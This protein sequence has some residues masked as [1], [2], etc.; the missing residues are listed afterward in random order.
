MRDSD[1]PGS[2]SETHVKH[3]KVLYLGLGSLLL[4]TAC[5]GGDE[6]VDGAIDAPPA[7]GAEADDARVPFVD[8][9]A[10]TGLDF[11]HFNGMSGRFYITEVTAGGVGMLDYDGDGD[12]DLYLP[13][14]A[15]LGPGVTMADVSFPATDGKPLID[16]LYRNDLATGAD[17]RPILRFTD[18]TEESGLAASGYGMGVASGDYDDDGDVD[19]YV[20]N[21]GPNQL[22]QNQ[23]DGTFR[24]V[25]AEAGADDP[26][27][28]V[29]ASFFDYDRDGR[30]DLWI[31]NYLDFTYENHKTCLSVTGAQDYC[32]PAAY[33]PQPDRLLHNEGGGRF[34]DVTREAGV[35]TAYGPALGTVAADLDDD[36]WLDMY[37]TNDG[38][39]NQ[40]WLN[41]HD[42]T[43]TDE[44]LMGGTAV[45]AEGVPEASMG[46]LAVDFTGDGR[47]DL[48]M[49][50]ITGETNTFYENLGGGLFRD[51][52]I[53]TGLAAPS[54]KAT[55][56][57]TAA[58]D[59]DNDGWVDIVAVNGAVRTIEEQA[60]RQV[61]YPLAQPDQLFR[62]VGD[63]R[64]EDLSERAGEAFAVERV[65]RGLAAGDVDNDGDVDLLILDSNAPARLL[66]NQVGQDR[67]WIGLRLLE[68]TGTRDALGAEAGLFRA[69]APPLWRRV[70]T[71]GSFAS[72]HD[73]RVLF[74]LGTETAVERL[75]VRWPSGRVE[76]FPPPPV[77]RY[78]TLTEGT[79]EAVA[80]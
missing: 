32:G 16:R 18:V 14:G 47:D 29:P 23:G 54:K 48:F 40:M 78:T 13:Q 21:L 75:E 17:G 59:Y 31:G 64:F 4:A 22:W 65:S 66:I 30:L 10:E 3:W 72:A 74:G 79:G 71:D 73:P 37:V 61:P 63:G 2:D 55:G 36:G 15:L 9:A 68:A 25:T 56:F 46:V 69:G 53:T 60:R 27:W 62:N 19:L 5:G 26:R 58:V 57:G 43:F 24:D 41:R 42:G 33:R 52:S 70:A 6:A 28:S 51:A 8:R 12:L 50:H 45:N 1:E 44:S 77:G 38:Q 39:P 49:T 67:P 76:E 35:H 34:R 80:R 11:V 20:T 7:A